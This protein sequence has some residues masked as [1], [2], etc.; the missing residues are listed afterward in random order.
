MVSV[1]VDADLRRR[2]RV[3]ASRQGKSV[4]RFVREILEE[5]VRPPRRTGGRR[6]GLLSLC[7]LAHG[8]LAGLDLDRELYGD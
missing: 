3:E 1:V 8:E 5:R 7:G 4:S 2:L 6:S